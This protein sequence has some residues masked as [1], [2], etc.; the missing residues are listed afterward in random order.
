MD[1]LSIIGYESM[2]IGYIKMMA[3]K[4]DS[5]CRKVNVLPQVGEFFFFKSQG[6][7]NYIHRVKSQTWLSLLLIKFY[8][9]A[10]IT[11]CFH[12]EI[13]DYNGSAT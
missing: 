13:T 2:C 10:A 9:N 1:L 12:T 4:Y 5:S 3:E 11:I 7:V 8:W 6:S